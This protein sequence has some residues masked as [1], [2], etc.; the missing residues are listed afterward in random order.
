MKT[1]LFVSVCVGACMVCCLFGAAG[2]SVR[3]DL[4]PT[5]SVPNA[6]MAAAM[7]A[8]PALYLIGGSGSPRG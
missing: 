3:L 8:F 2:Q 7:L 4:L 1:L 6:P 5:A